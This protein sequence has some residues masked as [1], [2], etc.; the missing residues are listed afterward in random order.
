VGGTK[1]GSSGSP[2]PTKQLHRRT[3]R[4]KAR[5]LRGEQ[6]GRKEPPHPP[7]VLLGM[8]LARSHGTHSNDTLKC[9]TNYELILTSQRSTGGLRQDVGNLAIPEGTFCGVRALASSKIAIVRILIPICTKTSL[10]I[11]RTSNCPNGATAG[12][13]LPAQRSAGSRGR[14]GSRAW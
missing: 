2:S 1:A 7:P 5:G 13:R 12:C 11:N 8:P 6:G 3:R 14:V 9:T 10:T 4:P